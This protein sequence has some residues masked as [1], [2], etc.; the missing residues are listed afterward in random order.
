MARCDRFHFAR[1]EVGR[2]NHDAVLLRKLKGLVA[3]EA[4]AKARRR[5]DRL[6]RSSREQ[7]DDRERLCF[8]ALADRQ[9]QEFADAAPADGTDDRH[10]RTLIS[11]R[12]RK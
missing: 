8:M 7:E 3:D 10:A 11:S 5:T 1:V 12:S 4:A 2:G 6:R 9:A